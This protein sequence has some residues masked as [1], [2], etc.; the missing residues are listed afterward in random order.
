[1]SIETVI[2]LMRETESGILFQGSQ[3]LQHAAVALLALFEG[4]TCAQ[5]RLLLKEANS[6]L[7]TAQGAVDMKRAVEL[8]TE[9][10]LL[11]DA[12]YQVLLESRLALRADPSALP[13]S[14]QSL[15]VCRPEAPQPIPVSGQGAEGAGCVR[16]DGGRLSQ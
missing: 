2:K 10:T 16:E 6:Q 9:L 1:M 4:F 12:R 3:K 11:Q 14:R 8:L 15:P 5:V 7:E 13:L